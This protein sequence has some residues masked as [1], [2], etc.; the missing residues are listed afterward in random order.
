[1]RDGVMYMQV[2]SQTAKV[3]EVDK[4]TNVSTIVA[5]L[6]AILA[7]LLLSQPSLLS[8]PQSEAPL[9]TPSSSCT[10]QAEPRVCCEVTTAFIDK[11]SG[12]VDKVSTG[13]VFF[14][15]LSSA[16]Y[17]VKERTV[18]AA[19][20]IGRNTTASVKTTTRGLK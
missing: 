12:M 19:N 17:C 10:C 14:K 11:V 9:L 3:D 16:L 6:Q 2:P 13:M 5:M 8:Q 18:W 20:L 1:M 15:Q 4:R 7:I